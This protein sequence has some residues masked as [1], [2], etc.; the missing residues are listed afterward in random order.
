[1]TAERQFFVEKMRGCG[2]VVIIGPIVYRLGHI[3][4]KDGSGVRFSVGSPF[5]FP[6]K[7]WVSPKIE[8]RI[9]ENRGKGM[10]AVEPISKGEEVVVWGGN[11][12]NKDQAEKARGE[13]K[14]VMQFDE[15]LFSI[16]DRGES[17]AYFINHSCEP[18][19]WMKD[20]FILEAMRDISVGAE[21]T[22]DYV[23]WETDENKVSKWECGC[24]SKK[25]RRIITG[26]DWKILELQEKYRGHF[27]PLIQKRIDH[28]K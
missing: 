13:G 8:I 3:L 1:M 9:T 2:R 12:V 21:L 16:E 26:K 17:D 6:Q 4:L 18:N 27:L 28:L 11:Y 10:F 15:D 22:A 24:G 23:L 14:L 5:M 7:D 19:V 25:C 20:V